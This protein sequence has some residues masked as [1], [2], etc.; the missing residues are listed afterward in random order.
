LV[1]IVF[2]AICSNKLI[3][4]FKLQTDNLLCC[5]ANHLNVVPSDCGCGKNGKCNAAQD[6]CQCNSGYSP[7]NSLQEDKCQDINECVVSHKCTNDR[8][9]VNKDGG[10]DCVCLG[11]EWNGQKCEVSVCDKSVRCPEHSSCDGSSGYPVCNCH[12]GYY[13]DG[14]ICKPGELT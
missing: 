13:R 1:Q 9:C 11:G 8:M 3:S 2:K 14:Q 5:I 12:E 7:V 6:G 4:F 10:Y